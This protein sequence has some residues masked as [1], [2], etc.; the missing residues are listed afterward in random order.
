MH[1]GKPMA[2]L[3]MASALIGAACGPIRSTATPLGETGEAPAFSLPNQ[4]DRQITLSA[5]TREGP[6]LL[7]FN[8]GHH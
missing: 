4:E 5:L 6:A 1:N 3:F 7:V 2:A 8:R